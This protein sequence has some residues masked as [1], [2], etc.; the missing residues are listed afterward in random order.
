MQQTIVISD[1]QLVKINAGP[2]EFRKAAR[3]LLMQQARTDDPHSFVFPMGT[4]YFNNGEL[5]E[6]LALSAPGRKDLAQY[7]FT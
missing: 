7:S 2:A 6:L 1:D 4:E 5:R 3:L